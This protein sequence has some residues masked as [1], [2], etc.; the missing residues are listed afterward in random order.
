MKILL[1]YFGV[2]SN[3]LRSTIRSLSLEKRFKN[4]AP[5]LIEN[6]FVY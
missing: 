4:I 1:A 2:F 5:D 6:A 3:A